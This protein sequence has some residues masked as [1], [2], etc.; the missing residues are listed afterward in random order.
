MFTD[1]VYEQP[2]E[3]DVD[4]ERARE[5]LLQTVE[6]D[7]KQL[8]VEAIELLDAY[9]IPTPEGEIVDNPAEAKAV[10]E[11]VGGPVAMKIVSPDIVHKS[12]IGGVEVGRR[13]TRRRG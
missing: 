7:I 9:G 5:I 13:L 2:T 12:D 1:R 8:G 6:R 11:R 4:R 3:F 10:A